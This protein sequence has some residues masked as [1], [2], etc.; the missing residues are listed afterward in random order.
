MKTRHRRARGFTY[1]GVLILLAVLATGAA[2]TLEFAQTRA[3]RDAEAELLGVGQEF[4]RAFASYY[5]Q[6]P[7]GQRPFPDK[8]ED[9]ARDPRY[10]GTRRHLRR[11]YP[12]PL[13]GKAWALVPAPGG[14]IMGVY[15]TATDK[16]FRQDIGQRALPPVT[17]ASALLVQ[18]ALMNAATPLP[19]PPASGT[20][21][22]FVGDSYAEWRFGYD[23]RADLQRRNNIIL[24]TRAPLPAP[25]ASGSVLLP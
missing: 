9:L 23:P 16:P 21:T 8:L 15:S 7:T 6:T 22:V 13:T 3:A 5:R 20:T 1:I 25:T 2:L 14:G 4:E 19:M 24:P 11:V 10:P 18:G 17:G 12:D